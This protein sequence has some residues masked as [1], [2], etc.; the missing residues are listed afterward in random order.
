MAL[1]I[2]NLSREEWKRKVKETLDKVKKAGAGRCKYH[3]SV[4]LMVEHCNCDALLIECIAIATSLVVPPEMKNR[5]KSLLKT[6]YNSP[7]YKKLYHKLCDD[8]DAWNG[9]LPDYMTDEPDYSWL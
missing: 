6:E 7:E 4:R 1:H 8:I 3:K 5:A 2:A 9:G